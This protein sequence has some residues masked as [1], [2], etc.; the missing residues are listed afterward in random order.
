[1]ETSMNDLGTARLIGKVAETDESLLPQWAKSAA[2]IQDETV[3]T[4]A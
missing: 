3:Q 2:Q 1:M 4:S